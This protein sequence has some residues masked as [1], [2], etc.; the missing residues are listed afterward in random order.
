MNQK[1]R[2]MAATVEDQGGNPY[3]IPLGGSNAIGALGYTS[4]VNE[5]IE[6]TQEADLQIDYVV[7]GSGSAGTHAGLVNGFHNLD[8]SVPVLGISVSKNKEELTHLVYNLTKEVAELSGAS[9][10]IPREFIHCF[11]SYVGDGYALPT[12]AMIESV[13]MLAK[14]EG[15]LLDTVYTGK[16]M[17]GLID[18]SRKNYFNKEDNV[19]FV[20]TGGL[21]TLFS[22][23]ELVLGKK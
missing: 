11:D 7:V 21:P 18:L 19:L 12:D 15:I 17:S 10:E 9:K 2:D 4:C 23:T 13:Q 3:I 14:T 1:M 22:N 8:V 16:V 20:H 5:I 6:Q